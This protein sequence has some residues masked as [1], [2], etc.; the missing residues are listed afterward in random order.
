MYLQS[1]WGLRCRIPLLITLKLM[2]R[3]KLLTKESLS[4]LSKRLKKTL[5]DGIRY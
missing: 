4:L 1:V 5:N 2:G 3:S